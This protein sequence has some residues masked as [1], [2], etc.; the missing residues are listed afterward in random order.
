M[1]CLDILP[2]LIFVFNL[3]LPSLLVQF[4]KFY[5]GQHSD[6]T[7]YPTSSSIMLEFAGLDL[8]N[9]FP[10]PLTEACPNLVT[11]SDLVMSHSNWTAILDYAVHT[12]GPLQTAN[13]SALSNVTWY[14]DR[15]QPYLKGLYKGY[16]VWDKS[17]IAKEA[18]DGTK[19]VPYYRMFSAC[20]LTLP[21]SHLQNLVHLRLK[22]LRLDGLF[23]YYR[24]LLQLVWDRCSKLFI[25]QCRH[26]GS[27]ERFARHRSDGQR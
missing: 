10:M 17:D 26:N 3:T 21:F 23:L 11:N 15:L 9:Y 25:P 13:G 22:G 24:P 7:A 8:T 2:S 14:E 4:T 19:Y 18:D 12:S 16:F 27:C 5:K 20:L 6:I 1:T